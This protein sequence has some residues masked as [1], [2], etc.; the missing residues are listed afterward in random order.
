M[1]KTE[2]NNISQFLVQLK[3]VENGT[4][5]VPQKSIFNSLLTISNEYGSMFILQT[6]SLVSGLTEQTPARLLKNMVWYTKEPHQIYSRDF[7]STG[8]KHKNI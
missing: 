7:D 5:L 6:L 4:M 1:A 8:I 3:I 2:L